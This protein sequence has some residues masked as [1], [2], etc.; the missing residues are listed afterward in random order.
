MN[1]AHEM[2]ELSK[3]KKYT[4]EEIL[5]DIKTQAI[6]NNQELYIQEELFDDS[7]VPK[8][9]ELGFKVTYDHGDFDMEWEI[10][11]NLSDE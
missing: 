3:V 5:T 7:L 11:W 9:K 6:K 4:L 10:S 1:L 2:Y 8:L